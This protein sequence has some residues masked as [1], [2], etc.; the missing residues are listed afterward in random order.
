[1]TFFLQF[2]WQWSP[3]GRKRGSVSGG[4]GT[5]YYG[6]D[7]EVD[8]YDEDADGSSCGT[9]H[10]WSTGEAANGTATS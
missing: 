8:G 9:L 7:N 3:G 1:M 6:D 4:P 2:T 10:W 5:W